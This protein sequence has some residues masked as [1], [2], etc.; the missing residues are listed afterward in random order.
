MF[1][2]FRCVEMFWYIL[3]CLEILRNIFGTKWSV[4]GRFWECFDFVVFWGCFVGGFLAHLNFYGSLECFA[5]FFVCCFL[6]FLGYFAT[7]LKTHE[8]IDGKSNF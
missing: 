6:T 3:E 1:W 8:K 7:F 2:V 5:K 4:E